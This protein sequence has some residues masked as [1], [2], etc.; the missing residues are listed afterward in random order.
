MQCKKTFT[1]GTL[2]KVKIYTIDDAVLV[3]TISTPAIEGYTPAPT[4]H[5]AV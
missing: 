1:D 2:G 4:D 3:G 5:L